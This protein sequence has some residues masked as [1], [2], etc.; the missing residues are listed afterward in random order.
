MDKYIIGIVDDE[1]IAI[2]K[3]KVSVEENIIAGAEAEFK[4]YLVNEVELNIDKLSEEILEDIE[5]NRITTLII[6]EKIMRN[7]TEIKGSKLYDFIK[8]KVGKF[9]IIILTNY[10]EDAENTYSVDPD[11][12]YEKIHFFNFNTEKG[13][14]LVN[15]IFI[16]AKIYKETRQKLERKM[17]ELED[18]IEKD[19][20]SGHIDDIN[21]IAEVADKLASLKPM[22]DNP[23][24][25]SMKTDELEKALEILKEANNILE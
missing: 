7:S 17:K 18:K 10:G 2:N 25:K 20:T 13:K 11:K 6:D 15:N 21:E 24:E 9:P 19:G 23:I 4:V 16:N 1:E 5:E 14:E 12:V 8:Q 3:I 22:Q